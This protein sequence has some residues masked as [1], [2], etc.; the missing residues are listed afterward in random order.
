VPGVTVTIVLGKVK[1]RSR[2]L[3]STDVYKFGQYA[4]VRVISNNETIE[5]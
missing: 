2:G 3:G 4:E 5:S 1:S